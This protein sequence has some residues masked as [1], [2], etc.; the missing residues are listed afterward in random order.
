ME[1]SQSTNDFLKTSPAI[2]PRM[3]LPQTAMRMSAIKPPQT[4][5]SGASGQF[6]R[7]CEHGPLANCSARFLVVTRQG[8][9]DE[10]THRK[11][12]TMITTSYN[13]QETLAAS[14]KVNSRI[15]DIIGG[16]KR[17]DFTK[18]FRFSDDARA[19]LANRP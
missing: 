7:T 17:L 11:E 13:Y 14:A 19:V 3:V 1:S 12:N 9:N 8:R 18:S 5:H 6:L 16:E 4:I 10:G 2:K 15:E